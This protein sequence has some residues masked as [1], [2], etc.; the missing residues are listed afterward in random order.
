V[1]PANRDTKPVEC[2]AR[3]HMG[4]EFHVY[5]Y[6]VAACKQARVVNGE[7]IQY[8][9]GE[10]LVFHGRRWR[11]ANAV[12]RSETQVDEAL[13]KLESAGW[14]FSLQG[15]RGEREQRRTARGRHT[16]IEY[17]VLE[18]DE[19]AMKHENCPPMRYDEETGE[20]IR[21]GRMAKAIEYKRIRALLPDLDLP[22]EFV[23]AIGRAMAAKKQ[24]EELQVILTPSVQ[25]NPCTDKEE[26]KE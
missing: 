11:I 23:E 17:Q 26:D 8:Q 19:Y 13:S 6:L 12:N 24:G 18:H 16:T 25:G 2:R 9:P 10:T 20:P 14:I 21:P 15:P 7:T 4:A 5:D 3:R 1:S 22:D